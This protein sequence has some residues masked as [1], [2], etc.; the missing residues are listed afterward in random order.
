MRSTRMKRTDDL[1]RRVISEAILTKLSDPRIGFVSV[2]GVRV[3]PEFDTA[4]VYVSVL[5]DEKARAETMRGLRSAASFLQSQLAREI[6]MRRTP[7]L[8][9]LYDGSLDRGFRVDA[10]LK[11]IH[12]RENQDDA[13]AGGDDAGSG[14]GEEGEGDAGGR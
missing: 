9:F 1:V 5:G 6:R 8:R 10:T 14:D 2:T 11:E 4:Q 3:S 12:D 7:R 13:D